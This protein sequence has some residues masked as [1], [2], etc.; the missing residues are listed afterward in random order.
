MR[1]L[2]DWLREIEQL[3]SEVYRQASA[4]YAD[5]PD[6][7]VFLEHL[8]E[9]ETWHSRVMGKAADYLQAEP[10]CIPAISMDKETS[11]RIERYFAD[12]E[13][14]LENKTLT[15]QA[16]IEKIIEAERS[17]W[18]HI[19][20]YVVNFLTEKNSEFGYPAARLQAHIKEIEYYVASLGSGAEFIQKFNELPKVWVESILIVDDEKMIT[21]LIQALLERSGKIDVAHDGQQALQLIENKYYK[22]IITDIDM[23]VMD[24]I[25]LYKE[26]ID[27]YP[28]TCS[29]FLFIT[30][31][32][33]PERQA[34]FDANQL[35]YLAKPMQIKTL[36]EEAD[37]ILLAR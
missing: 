32:L 6:F 15:K 29:R 2:I 20:L 19:F 17:E 16:L 28:K 27:K 31:D 18:N 5:D 4:L 24:G 36:K 7:S 22:L 30:G 1:K 13:E 3:A 11:D 10:T 9:D 37:R 26:V 34:F 21:S 12:M 23:P 14:G 25:S 33:S 35:R 8:A